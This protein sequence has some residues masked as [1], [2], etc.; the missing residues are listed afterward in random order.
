[1]KPYLTIDEILDRALILISQHEYF[2]SPIVFD[3]ANNPVR[4]TRLRTYNGFDLNY[5]GLT[6][7][8]FPYTYEGTSN[9]TVNSHNAAI[10]YEPYHVGS[11]D[12]GFDRAKVALVCRLQTT[13][14]KQE[15]TVFSPTSNIPVIER[16]ARETALYRW[17]TVLQ[18]ILLT[19]PIQNLGGL[20]KNSSVNWGEF[21]S[22]T[23]DG[24]KGK[25]Y[26]LH[27]ASLLWQM[28]IYVPR[29]WRELPSFI[30]INLSP[31]WVYVGLRRIDCTPIYWD[32]SKNN[33]VSVDGFV[34]YTSPQGQQVNYDPATKQLIDNITKQPLTTAQ[35]LDSRIAEPT[36]FIDLSF[37]LLGV[38][39]PD[40]K[41]LFYNRQSG[42]IVN[43]NGQ[44]IVTLPDGTSFNPVPGENGQLIDSTTGL[45][46]PDSQ[47]YQSIYNSNTNNNSGS[48]GSGNSNNNQNGISAPFSGGM[49]NIF[50][51][52]SLVLRDHFDL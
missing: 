42:S 32:S 47:S 19:K 3:S 21:S 33:L 45:P 50:D 37:V 52:N 40:R 34:V 43:C 46:I 13:G 41:Y 38:T 36:P 24:Q 10:V 16:S 14:T 15:E 5:S 12:S 39:L 29:N 31:S 35:L 30:G 20:I 1:M 23:W 2:K 7:S 22:V 44:P 6:L 17:L 9:V 11:G 26:V 18:G 4:I 48:N 25:N 28:E 8:L 27:S 51:A 49:V